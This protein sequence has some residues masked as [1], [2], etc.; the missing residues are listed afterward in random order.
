MAF[1]AGY[2]P[3]GYDPTLLSQDGVGSNSPT[4]PGDSSVSQYDDPGDG[5]QGWFELSCFEAGVG[6]QITADAVRCLAFDPARELLYVGAASGMLHAH[7]PEDTSR[8]AST[9]SHAVISAPDPAVRDAVAADCDAVIVAVPDGIRVLT[10]GGAPRAK[11]VADS[12]SDTQ[13]VSL[14]PLNSAHVAVGGGSTMLAVVDWQQQR[15]IR[16]ATLR[17]GN[18]VTCSDWVDV[19]GNG[20]SFVIFGTATG[21]VSLCDPSTMREFNAAASF[22]GAVTGMA[23]KGHILATCGMTTRAG[24]SYVEPVVKLYDVRSFTQPLAALP[25]APGPVAIAFDN[26][27]SSAITGG[28]ALWALSPLGVLQCLEISGL[29]SGQGVIPVSNEIHLEAGSDSFTTMKVS[30]EGLVACGD[31]GGFVHLWSASEQARVNA[32]SEPLWDTNRSAPCAVPPTPGFRLRHLE[33]SDVGATIPLAVFP[34]AHTLLS[35]DIDDGTGANEQGHRSFELDT[36]KA[37]GYGDAHVMGDRSSFDPLGGSQV[38]PGRGRHQNR[39]QD[40]S[41]RSKVPFARFPPKISSAILETAN[42]HDFVAYAKAPP[43][44]VRNSTKGHEVSPYTHRHRPSNRSQITS[45]DH[46]SHKLSSGSNTGISSPPSRQIVPP[47]STAKRIRGDRVAD[48]LETASEDDPVALAAIDMSP[49]SRTRYV[50]MD[51]VAWESVEGFNFRRFNESG[52]FC[53]LE[54]ALPNVYVNAAIQALYFTPPLRN[55]LN[56]HNCDRDACISC[57]LGF[58][59]SMLDSGGADAAVETGNF[60]KAFMTMAN[61]GALGLLDGSTSMPLAQRIESFTRYLLEQLHKDE[62]GSDSTMISV[63]TGADAISSGRFMPSGTVWERDSRPFQHALNY[64]SMPDEFAEL[65]QQ[66]LCRELEPTRAFCSATG[67]FESM[68]HVRQIASLP[69]LLLLGAS[70]QISDKYKQWWFRSPSKSASDTSCSTTAVTNSQYEQGVNEAMSNP[71]RVPQ[72]LHMEIDKVSRSLT[73][74]DSNQGTEDIHSAVDSLRKLSPFEV[75]KEAFQCEIDTG[76]L[77]AD[78]DLCFVIAHIPPIGGKQQLNT[79]AHVRNPDGHLVLYVRVPNSYMKKKS[80]DLGPK[81]DEDSSSNGGRAR[82]VEWWCFNDFSIA[83]CIHGL[84]EVTS[85]SENWK[86][87]C[88]FGYVRR[89]AGLR[90]PCIGKPDRAK[91]R[92]LIGPG[93]CNAA[94]GLGEDEAEPGPGRLF[95]LDCEFVMI[96]REDCEISGDG[97]RTVVTPARM[98]LARVSVVRGV[99]DLKGTP[100]IDDY[101]EVKETVVDYLTRFSGISDGDLDPGRSPYRVSP[102]KAVYKKLIA[103]VNAGVVFVG[104]GLKKDLRV[105][106]FAVPA[107]QVVDT[108][109]LFREPGKRLL[110]LRFLVATLVGATIQTDGGGGHDSVEDSRAALEVYN[111]YLKLLEAGTLPETIRNLYL[112]GYSHGWKADPEDPFV[113]SA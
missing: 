74:V 91:L 109:V 82:E 51:L 1:N 110:S 94:V 107:G 5:V 55:A 32:E 42:W 102:L 60:T 68:T 87:P 92:D 24:I 57:E 35:T 27:V 97:M 7:A 112:Y 18:S 53:G 33:T 80:L 58:L 77:S 78:Y 111:A 41:R 37:G 21:R 89:D 88:L 84:K 29:Q 85:F 106:N 104:H 50:E 31:T 2:Q 3:E 81:T 62:G 6:G 72:T 96:A 71:S 45:G 63:L 73:V 105:L 30:P 59:F 64:E 15:M 12:I 34:L 25:F 100:L 86:R 10:R 8:V 113:A 23:T 46:R 56:H 13:A 76:E 101:V 95:G 52:M 79:S 93:T 90:I 39:R 67:N 99:G 40:H 11:V 98:A 48:E 103:L 16:Q 19:R 66:S 28:D 83:P 36:G 47:S 44:F 54:N 69:N 108:V 20:G 22:A 26:W 49:G 70:A 65:V 61:A 9:P 43:G 17:G 14:N 38:K 4:F 75:E